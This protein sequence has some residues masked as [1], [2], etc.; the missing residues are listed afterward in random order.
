MKYCRI[1][2]SKLGPP[3]TS[4][5]KP[6]LTS[7]L[8]KMEIDT[9]IYVCKNCTHAQSRDLPNIDNYY[10]TEYKISLSTE[11]FDQL[12][13]VKNGKNIYRTD[14]QASLILKQNIKKALVFFAIR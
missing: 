2:C 5:S 1:C 4:I 7:N 6:S 13:R 3:L 12:F 11:E 8:A 14:F 10:D 9:V